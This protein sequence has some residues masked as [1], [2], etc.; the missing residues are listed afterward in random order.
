VLATYH[1][2][3]PYPD[4]REGLERLTAAGYDVYVLSNGNPEMLASM[5]E[6]AGIGDLLADTIS[7]DEVERFKP[8]PAVYRHG[9]AR[10]GTPIDRVLHVAG[11]SF[12]V[13]GAM[14]AG[15]QAAWLDRGDVPW[16]DF[17][18]RD[19]DLRAGTLG[20]VAD[21]LGV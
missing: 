7:A 20:D 21:A 3:E 10:T 1:D 17:A 4:V 5:V 12:D 2:L 15:M 16:E 19:P 18:G 6:S 11:P 14:H 9:A 13:L 8:D